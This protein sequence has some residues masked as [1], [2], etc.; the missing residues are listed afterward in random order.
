[1]PV[2]NAK[3]ISISYE[4]KKVIESVSFCVEKGDFLCIDF[5]LSSRQPE[6]EFHRQHPQRV[7]RRSNHTDEN[8]KQH[9]SRT[10]V[11]IHIHSSI[12][13]IETLSEGA[14]RLVSK[15]PFYPII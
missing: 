8:G 15:S 7:D 10:G 13:P 6:T 4:G 12:P 3:N 11:N 9:T 1:M 5:R 14:K 2:I